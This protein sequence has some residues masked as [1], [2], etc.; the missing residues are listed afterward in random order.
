MLLVSLKVEFEFFVNWNYESRLKVLVKIYI[1]VG[2][3]LFMRYGYLRFFIV[4][5]LLGV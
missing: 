5:F 1:D 3:E 4:F 2:K